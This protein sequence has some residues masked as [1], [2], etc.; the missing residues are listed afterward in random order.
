MTNRLVDPLRLGMPLALE[1]PERDDRERVPNEGR[2]RKKLACS[3]SALL[4]MLVAALVMVPVALADDDDDDD[5]AACAVGSAHG[6]FHTTFAGPDQHLVFFA[7][8]NG[9]PI[10][11]SGVAS[12]EN[13]PANFSYT[14]ELVC[15]SV[16][17]NT[18]RFGYVIPPGTSMPGLTGTNIVWGVTD[19][20][21]LGPDTAGW[22][23]APA[24]ACDTA[25]V[26]QQP[27]TSG[28]IVVQEGGGGDDDDD[29]D[30]D[31]DGDDDAGDD[32]D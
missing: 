9:A 29:D 15:V 7:C 2:S 14:A 20:N 19:S 30:D 10:D 1:W 32:D 11:D 26:V 13:V 8:D 16:V 27:I 5:A 4:V 21:G 12:Y 23:I 3:V 25:V 18:A 24:L 22:I 28:D 6:D 31:D 17:G